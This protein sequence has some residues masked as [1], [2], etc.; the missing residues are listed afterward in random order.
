[1]NNEQTLEISK[2]A[3]RGYANRGYYGARGMT[4]VGRLLD[5]IA[6]W[7]DGVFA[8]RAAY[9]RAR[10]RNSALAAALAQVSKQHAEFADRV[11]DLRHSVDDPWQLRQDVAVLLI[12]M[13]R[14]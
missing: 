9:A 13:A 4:V 6:L 5:R 11:Y 12:L 1:M 8:T 10:R 7:V 14:Q 3:N 2:D